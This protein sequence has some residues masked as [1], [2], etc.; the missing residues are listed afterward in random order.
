MA[1][2]AELAGVKEAAAGSIETAEHF[3]AG[4]RR[5]VRDEVAN[6]LDDFE[7]AL[8][9]AQGDVARIV[10]ESRRLGVRVAGLAGSVDLV[11]L[12]TVA[13]RLEDFLSCNGLSANPSLD[14][15]IRGF[16]DMMA[17]LAREE[18]PVDLPHLVREL[19]AK[20]AFEIGDIDIRNVEIMLVMPDGTQTHYVERELQQCGYRTNVVP[21]TL[22]ALARIVRTQPDMVI[23]NATMPNLGGIDFAIG[24]H[25]MPQT[26]NVPCALITSLGDENDYLKLLGP[27][28][29]VI[30]KGPDF[31]DNLFAALDRLFL[32]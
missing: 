19:P 8:A 28:V 22:D 16:T 26:R 6:L 9:G 4:M 30:H 1:D 12:Q 2:Q 21:S 31:A 29:P 17:R 5:E 3:T 11:D 32:L 10:A 7:L 18:K 25:A 20:C 13:E 27:G 15:D 14:A 24:L 23:V